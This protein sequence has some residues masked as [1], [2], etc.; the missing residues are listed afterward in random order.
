[1]RHCIPARCTVTAARE[2]EIHFPFL[3]GASA[4]SRLVH[5]LNAGLQSVAVISNARLT[6][7]W[8]FSAYEFRAI[9]LTLGRF[10]LCVR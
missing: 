5:L 3:I 10:V 4:T 9:D 6:A 8:N 7:G 2:A 1:M